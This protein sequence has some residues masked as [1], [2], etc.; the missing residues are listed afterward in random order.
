MLEPT[1]LHVEMLMPG[2]VFPNM[3][4]AQHLL[5]FLESC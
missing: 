3:Y 4:V 2:I 1:R 5:V